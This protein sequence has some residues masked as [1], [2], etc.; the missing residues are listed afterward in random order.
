MSDKTAF[1]ILKFNSDY[2]IEMEYPHRIRKIG[3]TQFISE[4]ENSYGYILVWING[5]NIYKHRLIALQ[6]IENDSPDTKI[7]VDHNNRIKTDNRIA[8]LRW[9]TPSENI[10][11]SKRPTKIEAEYLDE[12]PELTIEIAEYNGTEFDGYHYDYMHNR[13]I[14]EMNTGRIKVIK[15]LMYGNQLRIVLVDINKKRRTLSYAK[16]IRTIREILQ[17]QEDEIQSEHKKI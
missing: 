9:V 10:K 16:L 12:F 15:P 5:K 4:W 14:K 8:N 1:Q 11:N 7:Q 6:F 17:E 2:E 13:I 3:K